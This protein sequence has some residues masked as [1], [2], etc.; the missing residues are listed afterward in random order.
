MS[1]FNDIY[2]RDANDL[3]E[4]SSIHALKEMVK[5]LTEE[6][7]IAEAKE[8]YELLCVIK[9]AL[10]KVEVHQKRLEKTWAYATK[11]DDEKTSKSTF[12]DYMKNKGDN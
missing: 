2:V 1:A 6:D 8:T 5:F 9:E 3:F 11:Y 7:F 10:V 12:K 4:W